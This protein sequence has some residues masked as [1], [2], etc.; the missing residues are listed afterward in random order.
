MKE[1]RRLTF[2]A[3][4]DLHTMQELA[5]QLREAEQA[6]ADQD[7]ALQ[8][9]VSEFDKRE[10]QLRSQ[11]D[12]K[13]DVVQ[14]RQAE[15]QEE[16]ARL[17]HDMSEEVSMRQMLSTELEEKQREVD[18]Q[19][20]LV[21]VLQADLA[22]EKD[23]ANDLGVRL[24]EALLDFDGIKSQEESLRQQVDELRSERSTTLRH[25]S[26]AQMQSQDRESQVAGLRAE[27]AAIADQL[28]QARSD[29]DAALQ[30]QSADAE[31]M[32]RDHITEADGDR[33]VLE[34]Q[35]LTLTSELERLK[36][37]SQV[38]IAAAKSAAV[39]EKDGLKA[40]LAF[41]KAQLR[42][43]TR[44]ETVLA[45]E[46]ATAKDTSNAASQKEA[47]LT[48]RTREAVRVAMSYHECNS[49]IL[50]AINSSATI[51]GTASLTAPRPASP[52]SPSVASAD[53]QSESILSHS[54]ATAASFDLEAFADAVNRTMNLV[55]KW[56][57][58]CKQYREQAKHKIAFAN[59]TKGDLVR[60]TCLCDAANRLRRF[61]YPLG[62]R[63]QSHGLHSTVSAYGANRSSLKCPVSAPH[64]FL[65]MTD[66]ILDRM[67]GRDF[68][69]ARIVKSEEAMVTAEVG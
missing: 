60:G 54:L 66:A 31:R 33:A 65:K 56:Q 62:T 27:I 24:Q 47:R 45:D 8:A 6:K 14:R 64:N 69:V 57:K 2:A 15:L 11:H 30:Q 20:E 51:S 9:R 63:P 12:E 50:T 44:R 28:A 37:D 67:Q 18:E 53:D 35:N 36:A 5:D 23:R 21:S 46:L 10:R 34:H 26:E 55:R 22:Q 40:E 39:R 13:L 43:S 52:K 42:E 32:M 29:R 68:V 61:S 3:S 48:E 4:T 17:R 19:A 59:F 1:E 16:L 41:A 58:S 49:R 38:K 25:L 7:R